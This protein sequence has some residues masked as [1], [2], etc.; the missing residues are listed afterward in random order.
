MIKWLFDAP[1]GMPSISGR[2][3][4]IYDFD[5]CCI[6][7]QYFTVY[8]YEPYEYIYIYI[9]II[10]FYGPLTRYVK[11]RVAHAPGMSGAFFPPSTSKETASWW[12]DMHHSTCV[13]HAPWCM[14]GSLNCGGGETFPAF[15]V[16]A[17]PEILRI[18]QDAYAR[19]FVYLYVFIFLC[20]FGSFDIGY[21]IK[22]NCYSLLN[23]FRL[24][25]TVFK[26]SGSHLLT[27]INFN[28]SLDK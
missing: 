16:H 8:T 4:W 15:P 26:T 1:I 20:M 10:L 24:T 6:D 28:P 7:L 13:T 14:S 12:L 3:D 21:V 2:R 23:V 22:V 5:V 27:W 18:W 19:L 11:T 9:Y 17:Q 25:T